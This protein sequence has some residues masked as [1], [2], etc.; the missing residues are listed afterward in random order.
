MR[1]QSPPCRYII[2]IAPTPHCSPWRLGGFAA[3]SSAWL[4]RCSLPEH[5]R[6]EPG[7]AHRESR[8]R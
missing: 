4:N 1:F 7:D 6:D 3:R 8:R 2:M 5:G